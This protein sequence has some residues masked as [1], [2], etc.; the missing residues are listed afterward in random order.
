MLD[1]QSLTLQHWLSPAFPTGAFAYSHGLEQVVA[2]GEVTD[3]PG[4]ERWLADVLRFGTGWQDSVL[5][6][7]AL[8]SGADLSALDA[9]C[10]AVQPCAERLQETQEQGAAFARTVSQITGRDL[11]PR[12]LPIAVAEAAVPLGLGAQTVIAAYLQAFLTNLV[13]IGIRHV[14][15]GQGAGHGVLARLLPLVPELAQAAS[16]ASMDDLGNSCLGA[17]MAAME[18]ETKDVRLFRT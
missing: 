6:A 16:L 2:R 13:T 3:A 1:T 14:P 11:P 15:L 9:L 7:C 17:D 5:L 18:H 8:R 12:A 4:L 10:L